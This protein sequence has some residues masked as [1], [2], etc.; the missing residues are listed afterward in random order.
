[1]FKILFGV[2]I[3]IVSIKGRYVGAKLT[4]EEVLVHA[5]DGGLAVQLRQVRVVES[6]WQILFDIDIT[7]LQHMLEILSQKQNRIKE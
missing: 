4:P 7:H 3:L 6:Y 5:V 2:I 1:M